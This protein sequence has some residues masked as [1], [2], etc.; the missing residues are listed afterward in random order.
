MENGDPPPPVVV[1]AVQYTHV[2]VH[3]VRFK[4]KR[5]EKGA[6]RPT[7]QRPPPHHVFPWGLSLSRVK[8]LKIVGEGRTEDVALGKVSH[9]PHNRPHNLILPLLSSLPPPPFFA[10]AASEE[11]KISCHTAY[12]CVR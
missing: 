1:V 9:I 8:R 3:L 5:G 10:A 4:G 7:D 11:L 6:G 12:T 2:A